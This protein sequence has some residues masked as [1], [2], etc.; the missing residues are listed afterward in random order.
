MTTEK[1]TV[2]WIDDDL[3]LLSLCRERLER[4]GYHVFTAED[5]AAGIEMARRERPD[6]ILLDVIMPDMHGLE[7]CQQLR[8]DGELNDT[9]ILLMTALEDS[10][11]AAM[12][13][14]AGA[15]MTMRK[16]SDPDHIVQ[17][18]GRLLSP[19]AGA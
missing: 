1:T 9:P 4:S 10:G 18:I 8:A 16:P 14:K 7:V 12:G 19:K 5:G 6:V 15:T 17:I 13:R 2:L 11:V 3:L